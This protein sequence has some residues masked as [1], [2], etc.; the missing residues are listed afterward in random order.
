MSIKQCVNLLRGLSINSYK[1]TIPISC[2]LVHTTCR[3]LDLN[4]FFEDPKNWSKEEIKVGRSWRVAELRLK[5]NEDLHKLWYIL[6]KEKNMLL[7]MEHHCKE[8]YTLFPNPERIDKVEESMSNVETVVRERN[9]AYYQLETGETGERPGK[10]IHDPIGMKHWRNLTQHVIPKWNNKFFN[11]YNPQ[12]YDPNEVEQ[13]HK[14]FKEKNA[15]EIRSGKKKERRYVRALL[16][17]F[18]NLDI[19]YLKEQYPHFNFER[20]L[21]SSRVHGH[22]EKRLDIKKN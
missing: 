21:D 20:E 12:G 3:R 15:R 11:L 16:R 14:L 18:P 13:F 9:K 1:T 2:R 5:S 7:T 22:F 6:L 19:A 8:N 17:R 4:E 10:V